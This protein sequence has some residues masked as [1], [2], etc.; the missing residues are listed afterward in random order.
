MKEIWKPVTEMPEFYEVS[1]FGRVKTLRASAILS[2]G[3]L[4]KLRRDKYGYMRVVLAGDK[5][6][7]RVVH[8][9]VAFAFIGEP[10]DGCEVNHKD[11]NKENNRLSNL[12]YVTKS[13]N[14]LHSYHVLGNRQIRNGGWKAT[15][16]LRRFQDP[17]LQEAILLDAT[18][19][20]M[21]QSSLAKKYK[22]SVK[23]L[24]RLLDMHNTAPVYRT[25]REG[26]A[27]KQFGICWYS[28]LLKWVVRFTRN[29]ERIY[30][31]C[32]EN[33]EQ[34]IQVRDALLNNH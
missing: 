17:S 19:G 27:S 22:I 29:G 16:L 23:S 8:R 25:Y 12:E 7:S 18:S 20:V 11:G 28:G 9:L 4:L 13:E 15:S 5:H 10:P 6:Y 1:N 3:S 21:N 14:S 32:Y 33:I 31:G 2:A 34:A 30:G 24:N 26:A